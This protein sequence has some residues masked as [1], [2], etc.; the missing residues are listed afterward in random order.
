MF[1]Y[2][3]KDTESDKRI[4]NNNSLNGPMGPRAFLPKIGTNN[5]QQITKIPKI[6]KHG[7]PTNT[8]NCQKYQKHTKN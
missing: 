5:Y 8:K 3:E 7:D 2:T 4:K 1:I 6:K